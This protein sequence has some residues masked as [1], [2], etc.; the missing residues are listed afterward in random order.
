MHCF[1]GMQQR[2]KDSM[3]IESIH[4]LVCYIA[5]YAQHGVCITGGRDVA[6]GK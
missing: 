3:K 1:G 4:N 2:A 5:Q 6:E